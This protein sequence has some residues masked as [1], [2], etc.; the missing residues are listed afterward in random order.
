LATGS[1]PAGLALG[2]LG[3]TIGTLGGASARSQLAA[4]LH[5]DRPAAIIEDVVA[6]GGAA[7]AMALIA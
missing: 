2:V 5:N 6:I 4:R 7:L 3:A 1:W